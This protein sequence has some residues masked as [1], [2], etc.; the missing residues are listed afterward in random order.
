MD[1][2]LKTFIALLIT[3]T[4]IP[5]TVSAKENTKQNFNNNYNNI[6]LENINF[7]DDN[8]NDGKII[9]E[10]ND[11]GKT[12]RI[13]EYIKDNYKVVTSYIEIKQSDNS[14][15]LISQDL[16]IMTNDSIDL[17]SYDYTTLQSESYS[18]KINHDITEH[19]ISFEQSEVIPFGNSSEWVY[20]GTI[21]GSNKFA[22]FTLAFITQVIISIALPSTGVVSGI[23][24]TAASSIATYLIDK[25]IKTVYYKQSYYEK[26]SLDVS[27]YMVTGSK[28]VT[29]YYADSKRTK[30]LNTTTEIVYLSGYEE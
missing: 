29:K 12:Y 28:W 25:S 21:N 17:Y 10:M 16:S 7:I 30:Y 4:I 26:H 2:L 22:K 19:E 14:Y 9:Y 20:D 3:I 27:W 18:Y 24:S 23:T 8:I 15:K 6:E 13:T 11:N 5:A 1:K